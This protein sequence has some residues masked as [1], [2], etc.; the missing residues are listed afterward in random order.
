[1][2]Y[3][4]DILN[5]VLIFSIF[6]ISLNL[7]VGYTGQVSVAHAAFGAVGGY[8]AAFLSAKANWGFWAVLL[9]GAAGAGVVGVIMSLPALRL[10]PE[11]LVLL[12]IAV[13]SIVLTI[14]GAVPQLGG[15][16]GMVADKAADLWPLP[17]GELLF[18]RQWVLPLIGFTAFTYLVCHRMGESAWG[19]VLRGIRDDE[20]A[21]RALGCNV[22][23]SKVVV[24]GLTSAFAGLAG[25]LLYFYNQIASPSVYGLNV[26]LKIFAMTIF[27]GLGNFTGS[28]LGAA[29]LQLL[30]PMLEKLVRLDPGQAFLI[31]LVIYGLGLVVLV[32]VRPQGLLPEGLSLWR[33]RRDV[34]AA[35]APVP[36]AV[37]S[38]KVPAAVAALAAMPSADSSVI[39]K[40]RGLCK[41]FGGIHAVRDLDFDLQ[42][43][44]IVA[45][46]GPNGAGKTTVFNLLTG[47]LK[48]DRGSVELNGDDVRGLPPDRIARKGMVRSFQDVRLFGRMTAAENVMLGIHEA[49]PEVWRWPSGTRGGE[50]LVDLFLR[51]AETARVERETRARAMELLRLVGLAGVAETQAGALSFGQQK[52]VSFARLLGTDADVLLL[53]EPASGIDSRWVDGILELVAFMRDSGKTVCIVEHSLHVVER[54]ADTAIFMELGRITAQGT[55]RELTSDPRLAEVYFGTA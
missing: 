2:D 13:S 30:Q 44:R 54:L 46:V 27:G 33:R 51:P 15:A 29:V 25:V 48:S 4:W 23:A 55:V 45:L 19:R 32:R 34:P 28:I 3:W 5:L 7:L 6:T 43:G 49:A 42:R 50:N 38:I 41:S 39:L 10:A 22:F 14:V 18:P 17:G 16:Y 40:V 26:S 31:Q 37:A 35:M 9:T 52:L 12:T 21:T 20:T 11:Y 47:A 53:D 24:F 8:L 36:D 1:M